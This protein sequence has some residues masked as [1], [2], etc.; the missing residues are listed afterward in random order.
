MNDATDSERDADN[1]RD[2]PSASERDPAEDDHAMRT[3]RHRCGD[4]IADLVAPVSVYE[5]VLLAFAALD[6]RVE[7][8]EARTSAYGPQPSPEELEARGPLQ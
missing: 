3:I 1:E 2:D 7:E 6:A 8:I 4:E 5:A